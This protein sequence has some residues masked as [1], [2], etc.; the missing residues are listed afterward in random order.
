VLQMLRALRLTASLSL[1]S[2][3]AGC[4]CATESDAV[5]R[6]P[7]SAFVLVRRSPLVFHRA[8]VLNFEFDL[9]NV[10]GVGQVFVLPPEWRLRCW[11]RTDDGE[12]EPVGYRS[13]PMDYS[14]VV[15]VLLPLKPGESTGQTIDLGEVFDI[16]RTEAGKYRLEIATQA[17]GVR[18]GEQL[19]CTVDFI[20][21]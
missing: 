13:R 1:C 3:A 14:N 6:P 7:S 5:S 15:H 18:L 16:D 17:W 8:D 20:I 10:S 4:H 9:V 2:I 21:E 19:G 12:L 11:R